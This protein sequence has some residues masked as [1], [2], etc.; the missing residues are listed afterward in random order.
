MEVTERTSS[1]GRNGFTALKLK[2]LYT[3]AVLDLPTT[4]EIPKGIISFNKVLQGINERT[5]RKIVPPMEAIRESIDNDAPPSETEALIEALIADETQAEQD[6]FEKAFEE[7]A[8]A[9]ALATASEQDAFEQS[10]EAFAA[11]IAS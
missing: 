4:N 10:L 2:D 5:K 6:A 9:F 7:Q 8:H 1:R 3:D 11:S